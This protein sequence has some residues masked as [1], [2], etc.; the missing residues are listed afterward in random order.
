MLCTLVHEVH[1]IGSWAEL[2]GEED[3]SMEREKDEL[4]PALPATFVYGKI[5]ENIGGV[6]VGWDI[7]V[8]ESVL[9]VEIASVWEYIWES[10]EAESEHR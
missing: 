6:N 2:D 4:G 7:Q 10:K 5:E 3:E 9:Q 8:W 1:S